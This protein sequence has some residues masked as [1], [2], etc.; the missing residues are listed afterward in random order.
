[1][2]ILHVITGLS[3]DGAQRMLLRLCV[4]LS[5]TGVKSRV[6]SLGGPGELAPEFESQGVQVVPL[7]M[8]RP[9]RLVS[10]LL[11]LRQAARDFVPDIVQGWMYH[12]NLVS[13]F[14]REVP[15]SVAPVVWNIRR[16]LD[17]LAQRKR[18][19]QAVI[20]TSAWLSRRAR[21][22]VYCS[23]TSRRQHEAL[24]FGAQSGRVLGNGFDT[25]L[26]A[27]C[28]RNREAVRRELG[29][30][31][32]DVVIGNV[33]RYDVAKGHRHLLE[34]FARASRRFP[35]ARLLCVGRGVSWQAAERDGFFADQ[36]LRRRILLLPER[37]GISRLYSALDLYCSA[38]IAEG[39]PNAVAE[40]AS[41]G[42]PIVA[43][44]T[45]ATRD[46]VGAGGIV[47]PPR[48]ASALA[49]GMASLLREPL[50]RRH[51]IGAAARRGIVERHSLPQVLKGYR[52]LY[53]ELTV[54]RKGAILQ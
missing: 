25:A 27:P 32:G 44:D 15:P 38:S 46:I 7:G 14:A 41:C 31:P 3:G 34:A 9:H 8:G 35:Q 52:A 6:V 10:G 40:A 50:S 5:A 53:E 4:G 1:M 20:R 42:V 37:A 49:Q 19:T 45:G 22:V 21:A 17:D 2:K 28:A 43:T 36:E 12:A 11:A 23:H 24:G 54:G 29:F 39:F 47:V 33:G 51:E 18:S 30:G 48:S 13:L 16:G 26:F